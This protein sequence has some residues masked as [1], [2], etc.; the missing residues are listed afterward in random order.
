MSSLP[1]SYVIT[2][3]IAFIP[4]GMGANPYP[5]PENCWFAKVPAGSLVT[6]KKDVKVTLPDS[7]YQVVAAGP[8]FQ[9]NDHPFV[10]GDN[11]VL[12]NFKL[13]VAGGPNPPN[14]IPK[15]TRLEFT[16]IIA[17]NPPMKNCLRILVKHDWVD[18]L[19]FCTS[20]YN[21]MDLRVSD[22]R[23]LGKYAYDF[24]LSDSKTKTCWIPVP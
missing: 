17:A 12:M 15:K 21:L 18:S 22:F 24:K 11:W 19:D 8:I 20:V 6:L 3:L 1:L 14:V 13:P 2:A 7:N 9:L 23:L 4:S 16:Q 5:K 10:R